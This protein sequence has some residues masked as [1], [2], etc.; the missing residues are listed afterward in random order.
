MPGVEL[1]VGRCASLTAYNLKSS[2][3]MFGVASFLLSL[4][5]AKQLREEL[6]Y[7]TRLC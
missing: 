5:L 3:R 2:R 1:A 4:R 6:P 7:Q